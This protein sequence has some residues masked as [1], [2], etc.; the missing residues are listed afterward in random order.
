MVGV[1]RREVEILIYANVLESE[2]YLTRHF[3][4]KIGTRA[5]NSL[6]GDWAIK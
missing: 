4:E 5:V 6:G 2:A 3:R 1:G